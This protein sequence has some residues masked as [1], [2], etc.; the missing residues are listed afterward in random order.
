MYATNVTHTL[1]DPRKVKVDIQADSAPDTMPLNGADVTNLADDVT[2]EVGS[3]LLV[4]NP[5]AVYLYGEDDQWHLT[6]S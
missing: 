2:F 5:T 1:N 6:E 4:V 3:S